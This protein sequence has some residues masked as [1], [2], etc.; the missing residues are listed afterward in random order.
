MLYCGPH[1]T[2]SFHWKTLQAQI[3]LAIRSH[4]ESFV[5]HLTL[6][7]RRV[8]GKLDFLFWNPLFTAFV[9]ILVLHIHSFTTILLADKI[10][11]QKRRKAKTMRTLNA[12]QPLE[13]CLHNLHSSQWSRRTAAAATP[14]TADS[15]FAVFFC[16]ILLPTEKRRKKHLYCGMNFIF[17]LFFSQAFYSKH[18]S[19]QLLFVRITVT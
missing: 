11:T 7:Q 2:F 16:S 13:I 19:R 1:R 9:C 4:S 12:Y 6:Q 3:M 18:F 14:T 5:V 8:F 10:K 15:R 17:A